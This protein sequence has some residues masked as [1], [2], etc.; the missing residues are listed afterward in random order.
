MNLQRILRFHR[1][2]GVT[3]TDFQVLFAKDTLWGSEGI[4]CMQFE[5]PFGSAL[6]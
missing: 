5:T 2:L 1:R 4:L 6:H 3:E